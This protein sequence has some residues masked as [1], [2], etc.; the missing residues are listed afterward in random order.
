MFRVIFCLFLSQFITTSIAYQSYRGYKLFHINT[1][2]E[3]APLLEQ[4]ETDGVQIDE[5]TGK[6]RLLIDVWAEPH[7]QRNYAHVMVAPEFTKTFKELLE[8]EGFTDYRI[9]KRDIQKDI[10]RSH[11]RS[12]VRKS[13]RYRRKI[14]SSAEFNINEYH[15]YD[16]IVDYLNKVSEENLNLTQK[17]EIGDTFEGRKLIGI[18]IG[19]NVRKFKPAVFIDAGIHSREWI[20]PASAL[21]LIN[22]VT[23]CLTTKF[24]LILNF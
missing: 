7:R 20:A 6:P 9:I 11:W 3:I 15:N 1:V 10:D 23:F 18:K 14:S 8:A 19:S 21:Y 4:L 17:F 12:T 2:E 5:D 16:A 22:K 13:R 24:R